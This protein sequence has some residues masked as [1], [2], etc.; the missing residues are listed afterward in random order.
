M[1][2]PQEMGTQDDNTSGIFRK[3]IL[4]HYKKY[5][6]KVRQNFWG[7]DQFEVIFFILN[8]FSCITLH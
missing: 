6:P 3:P 7:A 1:G 8:I 2:V 5:T 4:F